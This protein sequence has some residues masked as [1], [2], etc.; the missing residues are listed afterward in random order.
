MCFGNNMS[1]VQIDGRPVARGDYLF[2]R[3]TKLSDLLV[4]TVDQVFYY[5][6]DISCKRPLNYETDH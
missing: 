3:A 2:F 5:C 4:R 6:G 1:E